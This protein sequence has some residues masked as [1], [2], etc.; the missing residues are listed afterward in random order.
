M[1]EDSKF[2]KEEF[3][4]RLQEGDNTL[5]VVGTVMILIPIMAIFFLTGGSEGSK[6]LS[7]EAMRGRVQRKNVFNFGTKNEK[8]G[9]TAAPRSGSSSPSSGWFT[10]RTPEQQVAD[11]LS[12][13]FQSVEKSMENIEAPSDIPYE[14]QLMYEAEHNYDL[15]KARGEMQHGNYAEAAKYLGKILDSGN[16]N[17]FLKAYTYS[18]LCSVYEALGDKKKLEQAIK[19]Y[20]ESIKHLPEG[21]GGDLQRSVRDLYKCLQAVSE[22][23]DPGK[24]S[25]A[26]SNDRDLLSTGL[27]SGVNLKEAYRNFP[28]K[29]E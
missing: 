9:Y 23:A 22:Y 2:S 29:Y 16:D 5:L 26:V 24:V 8:G 14:A 18:A 15:C 7:R 3:L 1:N 13:A 11:E 21:Y 10:A 27:T 6:N 12:S 19:D 20:I 17:P 4:K 28:V 25:E